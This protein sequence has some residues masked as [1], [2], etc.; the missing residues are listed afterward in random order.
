VETLIQDLRFGLRIFRKSPGFT[1]IA[2][3]TLALGIGANTAIFSIV[4]GVLLAPLPYREPDRLVTVWL[5]NFRLKSPTDLSYR[6]FMDWEHGAP[7]FEKMSAYAWRSFDLSSPGNPEHLAGREISSGFLSTLGVGLAL[8][9]EFS[10]EEDRNGGAPVAIISNGLWRD[11]FGGSATALGESIVL[12]GIE[13]TVVGVLQQGFR[14]GTD[15]AD[16]YIPIGQRKLVDANDRTVHDVMCVARLKPGVSL[17]QANAEMNAI[18]EN[19]DRLNPETEQGLGARILPAKEPLVGDVRGT[20]LL[21]LGAVGVVLLIACANVANLLLARS[22]ARA[23]EFSIRA[24]LGASRGRIVRQLVTESVLLSILG[25]V[26]GLAAAIWSL[27]AGLA[28]LAAD[29]PRSDN[30]HVNA[31]VLFFALGISIVVGILFGLTPALSSSR[32]D[33]QPSLME[34]GRGSTGGH[35]RTQSGLVIAQMALTLVLLAGAGLLFRTIQHLWKADLGF[36]SQHVLTFQ[37]GLS[38]SAIKTG[39]GVRAAYQEL[40]DRIRQIPGIQGAE[41]TTEVPMTHQMNSIPFWVDSHRPA[42]VAEAPRTLGFI[43]GP[44][45]LQVMRIPLI[46]GRFISQ[47]DTVNSPLVA[48]IDSEL[49]RVYFPGKDPIGRTITFPQVGDYQIIGVVGHVQ[50]W[51]VGFSSPFMQNQSYVSIYQVQDRWMTTIDTW[52]WVVVRT[53]LDASIVLPEIRKAVFGAAGDQT[54]YHAQSMAEIVSESMSPQRFPLIL[55]GSFATLGL[56]LASIGIYGVMSYS[57]TQRVHEIGIRMALGAEKRDVF[58]IVVGQGLTLALAGLAIGVTAALILTRLLLSFS[59]LL[60]GVG[61]SDPAT[62]VSVSAVLFGVAS[63]ACYL[64]AR[65][66]M[67]VDPMVA[68]RHD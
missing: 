30:I 24:A 43:T 56:F 62:L 64:P 20:L 65:R 6:D 40:L 31:S 60:Y 17:S 66:A 8:G 4:Q 3:L 54:V 22:A 48:V 59:H 38:P 9:R 25:G 44:D 42:S 49:A 63:L 32:R 57:V 47:Q 53:P 37:V 2:I 29:L 68:L 50:H 51:Q 35:Q 13:T 19:I 39:V 1:A 41:I 27:N 23:R 61:A 21:L 14:F 5:N 15:Y 28:T 16:V 36:E 67:R 55:L 58:R 46:R 11:R 10:K 12:D 7:P 18:Q 26:L 45:F 33:L 52:T 34:G